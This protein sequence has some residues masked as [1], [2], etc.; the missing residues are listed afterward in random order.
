MGGDFDHFRHFVQRALSEIDSDAAHHAALKLAGGPA[1]TPPADSPARPS[2]SAYPSLRQAQ[3]NGVQ[4]PG[5]TAGGPA[6]PAQPQKSD[7]RG[8]LGAQLEKMWRGHERA[9]SE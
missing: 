7:Q 4:S 8:K 6:A 5:R 9:Q 2:G 3:H 1:R